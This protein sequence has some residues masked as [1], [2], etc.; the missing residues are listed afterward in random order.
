MRRFGL[1]AGRRDR[2]TS[3][4]GW[5][6]PGEVRRAD[7][8]TL[9]RLVAEAENAGF[10]RTGRRIDTSA[11]DNTRYL[12]V[13]VLPESVP[14][15]SWIC[16]LLAY[17]PDAFGGKRSPLRRVP[18]RLDVAPRTYGRLRPLPRRQKNQLLHALI[19]A[20]P[21]ATESPES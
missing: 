7:T 4:F 1:L 2:V 16:I 10:S 13:P 17:E 9:R 19:W 15:Q 8:R 12:L 6:V 20:L 21:A 5:P 11:D 18:H 3:P 14:S